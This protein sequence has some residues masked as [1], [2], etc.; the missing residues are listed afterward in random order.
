VTGRVVSE[1][2]HVIKGQVI[3]DP[4]NVNRRSAQAR[5]G[6]IRPDG[7]YE[8]TTLIGLNRVT[9][10]IPGRPGAKKGAPYIQKVFDVQSG[11]N[12]LDI[13]VP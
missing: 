6:D 7:T 13:T 10:A 2:E 8:V 12:N 4:S 1:G 11:D 3:L 9:V 5:T